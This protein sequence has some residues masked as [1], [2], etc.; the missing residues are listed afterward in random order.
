MAVNLNTILDSVSKNSTPSGSEESV[1]GIASSPLASGVPV[2]VG[3]SLLPSAQQS[4]T[5]RLFGGGDVSRTGGNQGDREQVNPS[6][7][8]KLPRIYG[9][10]TTGGVV[11]DVHKESAN[12][13]WA[14]VALTEMD[15]N[16]FDQANS[17]IQLG[18]QPAW[19]TLNLY[20]DNQECIF[21]GGGGPNH[22]VVSGQTKVIRLD[23]IDDPSSNAEISAANVINM[24]AWAGNS[25]ST[26]QIFPYNG[27]DGHPGPNAYDVFP[28]WTSANT[29]ENT[30]FAILKVGRLNEDMDPTANVEID[31]F[32]EFSFKIESQ[33]YIPVSGVSGEYRALNNPAVALQDYL[34]DPVYGCGLSNADIDLNSFDDWREWCD[35]AYAYASYSPSGSSVTFPDATTGYI[36]DTTKRVTNVFL[37]TQDPVI[38]NIIK[39]TQSGSATLTYDTKQGKFRAL[40]N[41]PITTTEETNAFVFDNNNIISSI[42]VNSTDLYSLY[43]FTEVSFPNYLQQ[44]KVDNLIV[45]IPI[46][47]RVSNE[48]T[49]GTNYSIPGISER[50]RASD[51]AN[52]SLKQ[53]RINNTTSFTADHTSMGVAVG[54]FAKITDTTKGFENKIVTIMRVNEREQEDGT[55]VF[56]YVTLDYSDEPYVDYYYLDAVDAPIGGA[57]GSFEN[58]LGTMS[59][60]DFYTTYEIPYGTAGGY[61]TR[62]VGNIFVVNETDTGNGNI[63]NYTGALLQTNDVASQ[64][65]TEAG[66]PGI[67]DSNNNPWIAIKGSA[68]RSL[69]PLA[70]D[71][72][73]QYITLTNVDGDGTGS[74]AL[75]STTVKFDL[76]G[77]DSSNWGSFPLNKLTT[78]NYQISL[79][80]EN[81]NRYPA[82]ESIYSTTVGNI[83]IY[84]LDNDIPNI[85]NL[86]DD[87]YGPGTQIVDA[88]GPLNQSGNLDDTKIYPRQ[89]DICNIAHATFEVS[90]NLWCQWSANV[91]YSDLRLSPTANITFENKSNIDSQTF[92]VPM[93]GIDYIDAGEGGNLNT[94]RSTWVNNVSTIS[95][96]ASD[97]GLD[98]NY[99]PARLRTDLITRHNDITGLAF[100]GEMHFTHVPHAY[101]YKT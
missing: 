51:I 87:T 75:N 4:Q 46:A 66:V 22:V 86:T 98:S 25:D 15:G 3:T 24:W 39:I 36:H 91:S 57:F 101:R 78:G 1:R 52:V 20:R 35:T 21:T 28:T 63:F 99:Y 9:A 16:R 90:T 54:D 79:Q 96:V 84:D 17:G 18:F 67:I 53:S 12:V 11:V 34:I 43:N 94:V 5:T 82:R 100:Y 76:P 7:D 45:D 37:N 59:N 56:D 10:V 33:G 42:S 83:A 73:S 31:E 69:Y 19:E 93:P 97:Y 55:L 89:Y 60:E 61:A 49:S 70:A 47:D 95:T 26:S 68:N 92:N 40:V 44:D 74:P 2:G 6:T 13:I 62:Y 48:P 58:G 41:K 14:C 27:A 38:D 88:F 50:Y 71:W 29:M 30:V 85:T 64:M 8:N 65:A 23:D 77:T 81:P 80:Y 32:G 72:V